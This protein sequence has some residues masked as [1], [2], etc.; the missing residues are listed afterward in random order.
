V[1]NM[2]NVYGR[3]IDLDEPLSDNDRQFLEERQ[4]MPMPPGV[5]QAIEDYDAAEDYDEDEEPDE[6]DGMTN[7]ELRTELKNRGLSTSGSKSQMISRLE[8]NDAANRDG[9]EE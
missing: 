9:S 4:G 3:A 8:E 1:G 7:E 5:R 6:Y 2:V